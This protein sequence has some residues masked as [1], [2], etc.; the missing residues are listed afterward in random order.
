MNCTGQQFGSC[1]QYDVMVWALFL[2]P[3]L[4]TVN[5]SGSCYLQFPTAPGSRVLQREGELGRSLL[6]SVEGQLSGTIEFPPLVLPATSAKSSSTIVIA[7]AA[8]GV[9][10]LAMVA[11]ALVM[12]KKKHATKDTLTKRQVVEV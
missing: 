10:V 4:N 8:A 12:K 9:G 11:L 3:S 6:S 5:V 7:S 1:V 2:D